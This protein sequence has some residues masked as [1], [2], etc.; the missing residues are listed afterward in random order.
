MV[1]VLCLLFQ[2][3]R[4]MNEISALKQKV[5]I[6]SIYIDILG[7]GDAFGIQNL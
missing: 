3:D 1:I 5:R 6:F 7:T 2:G 4:I